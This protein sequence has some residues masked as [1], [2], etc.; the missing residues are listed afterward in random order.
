MPMS[1]LGKANRLRFGE[2]A[3]D[4]TAGEVFKHGTKVP[5]QDKPFQILALLLR[6]PKQ[7]LSRQEIIRNVW[8]DTFVEGDLCLNVAI[9]RLRSALNDDA[10]HAH[11]I[12]TV[13]SHGYRFIAAVHGS[14]TSEA[15]VADRERPRVA[16]FP[17]KSFMGTQSDC[18]AAS[19]TELLIIQLRR[20]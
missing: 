16:L 7:L 9:R 18:F 4:L 10:S 5:L 8:P 20:M 6:R 19:I 15:V 3:A 13:G 17:L 1:D 2:F 11:L 14:P 12:E